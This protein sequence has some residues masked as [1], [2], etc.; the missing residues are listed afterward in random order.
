M[1]ETILYID[2]DILNNLKTINF[3]YEHT[4]LGN[5]S[6]IVSK[7]AYDILTKNYRQME[8]TPVLL[9]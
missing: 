4:P 7:A 9:I 8:F 1:D 2:K 3:T 5:G 6:I